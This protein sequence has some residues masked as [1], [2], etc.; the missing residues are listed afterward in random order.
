ML[1]LLGYGCCSNHCFRRGLCWCIGAGC[2]GREKRSALR[3]ESPEFQTNRKLLTFRVHSFFNIDG[4]GAWHMSDSGRYSLVYAQRTHNKKVSDPKALCYFLRP[5]GRRVRALGRKPCWAL[6]TWSGR[7]M[8]KGKA[9][10]PASC[11]RMGQQSAC[12]QI[13]VPFKVNRRPWADR[14]IYVR[15]ECINSITKRKLLSI[16]S[17]AALK[18]LARARAQKLSRSRKRV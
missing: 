18:F 7:C 16:K 8:K 3:L 2:M 6:L 11:L 10:A 12:T 4:D 5:V 13:Y 9:A 15:N 1:G 14:Q 17:E